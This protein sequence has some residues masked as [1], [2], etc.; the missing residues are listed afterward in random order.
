[1]R[2]Q[3]CLALL[4]AFGCIN[5]HSAKAEESHSGWFL[6]RKL[7][8]QNTE[9]RFEVDSTWHLVEGTVTNFTGEAHLEDPT[10]PTSVTLQLRFSVS[11]FDTKNSMRDRKMKRVMAAQQF[12]FVYFK[13]QG[14]TKKCTPALVLRDGSCS[15]SLTGEL[16]ILST[17]KTVTLPISIKTAE[18]D[19]FFVKGEA[20]FR[21]EEYGVKDP[22]ILIARLDP[23]VTV[24]FEVTLSP[25]TTNNT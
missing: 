19:S 9:V 18:K 20:S 16:T 22:S 14:L 6:P 3:L 17:K 1:M 11:N 21:W 15:D 25:E 5:S 23:V 4:V 7:S 10:D 13:A 12:P 8:D 2:K 24:F